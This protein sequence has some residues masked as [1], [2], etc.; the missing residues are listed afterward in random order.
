[1]W[2][3]EVYRKNKK[4]QN[5]SELVKKLVAD[6]ENH[7]G[8]VWFRGHADI[9]WNLKPN[10]LRSANPASEMNL[11]KKFKQSGTLLLDPKPNSLLDWLLIMQH[12][13]MPTRL[14]DWSESPLVA[15]YFS[16]NELPNK[17]GALWMLRPV[18]LNKLSGVEPEYEYDIPS[19][20]DNILQTYTPESLAGER[21]SKLLPI[22]AIFPRNNERMQAQLGVFTISHRDNKPIEEI[23]NKKHIWKYVIPANCKATF[24]K[25]LKMLGFGKFQLFPELSSIGAV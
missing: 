4:V 20:E 10:F 2:E 15:A 1:L 14:L 6:L 19:V 8:P 7:G 21:T 9:S 12:H 23:G 3:V 24:R 11:I 25:E 17:D 18:E 5:V 13:G 16:V 22:A